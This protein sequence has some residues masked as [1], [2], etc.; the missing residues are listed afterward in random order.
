MQKELILKVTGPGQRT[1]KELFWCEQG[2]SPKG[3]CCSQMVT[4]VL[5]PLSQA[6]GRRHVA[7][8]AQH[9]WPLAFL[10]SAPVAPWGHQ[11]VIYLDL[12]L[13]F[14]LL[15]F[16]LSIHFFFHSALVAKVSKKMALRP[17]VSVRPFLW[18]KIYMHWT[19][20]SYVS[21]IVTLNSVPTR[22][23]FLEEA[24]FLLRKL[25]PGWCL[26]ETYRTFVYHLLTLLK[27]E[28][29]SGG[30]VIGKAQE[31]F[32]NSFKGIAHGRPGEELPPR[33]PRA[34]VWT[35][36][37][38]LQISRRASRTRWTPSSGL[39][40]VHTATGRHCWEKGRS[41]LWTG[42]QS[43]GWRLTGTGVKNTGLLRLMWV[44]K[45]SL[46]SG[47]SFLIHWEMSPQPFQIFPRKK[48]GLL[49]LLDDEQQLFCSEPRS[50][51]HECPAASRGMPETAGCTGLLTPG[52][53]PEIKIV[54]PGSYL[55][56][57]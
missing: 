22:W 8:L 15:P 20:D 1:K 38:D 11:L 40:H 24:S 34:G 46:V 39:S 37:R 18:K 19:D 54:T 43:P 17:R 21:G 12:G 57:G 53:E 48:I 4:D 9:S 36:D 33:K 35:S 28:F 45:R 50:T 27:T 23:T 49:S 56:L 41:R 14:L 44:F 26:A 2:G 7:Q 29:A 16:S 55:E 31:L 52:Q 25:T 32:C 42:A 47:K 5:D 10:I 30:W 6:L 13:I 51:V 3:G